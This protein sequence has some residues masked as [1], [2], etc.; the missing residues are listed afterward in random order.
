VNCLEK[1]NEVL[2]RSRPDGPRS[3][4]IAFPSS[5]VFLESDSRVGLKV[6]LSFGEVL[7]AASQ[8]ELAEAGSGNEDSTTYPKKSGGFFHRTNRAAEP[9]ESAARGITKFS[10]QSYVVSLAYEHD[11]TFTKGRR[12]YLSTG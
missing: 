12:L 3:S 6:V 5:L 2:S 4:C 8:F 1:D 9:L 11:Y 7:R 10:R